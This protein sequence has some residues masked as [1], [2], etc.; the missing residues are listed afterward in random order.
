MVK[1]VDDSDDDD[2]DDRGPLGE[3][4]RAHSCQLPANEESSSYFNNV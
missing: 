1:L 4:P 2:S 3:R